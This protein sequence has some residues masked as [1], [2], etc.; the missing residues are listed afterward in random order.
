MKFRS[1]FFFLDALPF[2]KFFQNFSIK[3][4]RDILK[5]RYYDTVAKRLQYPI[6]VYR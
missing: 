1:K 6:P 5:N 2:I 4:V 3:I